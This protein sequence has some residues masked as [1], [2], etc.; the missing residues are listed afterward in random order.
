MGEVISRSTRA[1][2][3]EVAPLEDG[4]ILFDPESKQFFMLNRSAAMLWD[5]LEKE[6]SSDE[7][8][9][10]LC[11]QF[12]ELSMDDARRDVEQALKDLDEAGLITRR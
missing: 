8:A 7:L 5:E 6:A 9:G 4:S 3:V 2:D 12:P 11:A 10:K 1:G